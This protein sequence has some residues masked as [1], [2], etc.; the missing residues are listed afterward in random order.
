MLVFRS[1]VL[2]LAFLFILISQ[3]IVLD[4]VR[5]LLFYRLTPAIFLFIWVITTLFFNKKLVVDTSIHGIKILKW[6]KALRLIS[7]AFIIIGA[8][9]KVM[10]W[11][12]GDI[13]LMIGIGS[14]AAYSSIL[15]YVAKTKQE[16][17]PEIIDDL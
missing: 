15:A 4:T 9:I 3:F 5:L 7:S 8:A 1:I 11:D 16:H 17:N 12:Y 2:W 13:F 10:R 6:I 14:M